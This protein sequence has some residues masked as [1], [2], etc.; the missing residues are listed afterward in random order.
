MRRCLVRECASP[1]A[2]IHT[3][4]SSS[5]HAGEL[6]SISG[7]ESDSSEEDSLSRNGG[8]RG[9]GVAL[10]QVA[11]PLLY[12]TTPSD[13]SHAVFRCILPQPKVT[14]AASPT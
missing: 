2:R 10:T 7:S 4:P 1:P 13:S 5:L 14:H 9:E 8:E 11:S 3:C 12:F 6:S